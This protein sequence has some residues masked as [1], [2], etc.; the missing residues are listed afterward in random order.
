MKE[1]YPVILA[2]AI[3]G[4]MAVLLVLLG[5]PANM[6]FC[7]A[8]FLRDITGGLGLHRA[9]VVQYLRPEIMGLELGAFLSELYFREFNNRGDTSDMMRL[10]LC[11]GSCRVVIFFWCLGGHPVF[12][13]GLYAGPGHR[14]APGQRLGGANACYWAAAAGINSPCFYFFQ[15]RRTRLHEGSA[16]HCSCCRPF[17]RFSG[18]AFQ[19]LHHGRVP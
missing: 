16:V 15:C 18:A 12:K 11:C 4:I 9:A 8:C 14:T 7:I 2:G 10:V 13:N 6:G 3:F 19:I 5:N 17:G 1:K